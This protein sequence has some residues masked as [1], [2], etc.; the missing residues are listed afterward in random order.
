MPF[1]S[2]PINPDGCAP[3]GLKYRSKTPVTFICNTCVFQNIFT[4]ILGLSIWVCNLL[5]VIDCSVSVFTLPY[6]V[7]DEENTKRLY[8]VFT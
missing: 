2:S 6:T 1:G 7:A 4:H 5:S 8:R 3:T